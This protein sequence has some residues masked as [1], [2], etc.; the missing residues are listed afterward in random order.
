MGWV[1]LTLLLLQLFVVFDEDGLQLHHPLLPV[2]HALRERLLREHLRLLLD[3][4][5]L[6]LQLGLL[7][8]EL[9]LALVEELLQRGLGAETVLRFHDGPLHVDDGKLE[10]LG[11]GLGSEQAKEHGHR[12]GAEENVLH[13]EPA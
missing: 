4:F 2:F 11:R 9:L 7:G 5:A 8:V 12:K 10:L 1:Q 6:L 3:V 13:G